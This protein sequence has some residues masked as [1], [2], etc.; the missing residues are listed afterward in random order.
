MRRGLSVEVTGQFLMVLPGQRLGVGLA[1]GDLGVRGKLTEGTG[2]EVSF[3][4]APVMP[5]LMLALLDRLSLHLTDGDAA[6]VVRD[7]GPTTPL[8]AAS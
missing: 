2:D 6:D 3:S 1:A 4:G 5:L 7:H 8:Q